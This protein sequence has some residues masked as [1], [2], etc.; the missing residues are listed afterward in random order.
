MAVVVVTALETAKQVQ[1]FEAT[2]KETRGLAVEGPA[3]GRF[4]INVQQ[5]LEAYRFALSGFMSA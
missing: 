2:A 3:A 5:F 1:R 4:P